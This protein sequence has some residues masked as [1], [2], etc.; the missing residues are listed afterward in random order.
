MLS[1]YAC[2]IVYFL[3]MDDIL[4]LQL[5]H[6]LKVSMEAKVSWVGLIVTVKLDISTVLT[7]AKSWEPAYSQAHIQNC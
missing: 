4:S 2:H 3:W 1:F 5:Y 6:K 7:K